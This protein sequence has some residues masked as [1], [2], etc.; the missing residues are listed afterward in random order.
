[1]LQPSSTHVPNIKYASSVNYIITALIVGKMRIEYEA[2]WD[3]TRLELM[4][5]ITTGG[6]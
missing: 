5:N 4:K 1:M 6:R 2:F 3:L